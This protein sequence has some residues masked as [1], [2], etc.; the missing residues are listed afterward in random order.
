MR[1]ESTPVSALTVA[2]RRLRLALHKEKVYKNLKS[3]G[4]YRLFAPAFE[5]LHRFRVRQARSSLRRCKSKQRQRPA[6]EKSAILQ[7]LL[8]EI[9]N[10]AQA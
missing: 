2:Q 9:A 4:R 7:A 6:A 10:E 8:N 3:L 1:I 5:W